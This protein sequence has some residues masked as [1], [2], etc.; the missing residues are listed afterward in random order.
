M[1]KIDAVQDLIKS[2]LSMLILS[3]LRDPRIGMVSVNDVRLSPDKRYAKVYISV[4][5]ND[6]EKKQSIEALQNAAGFLRTKV[7]HSVKL[8]HTPELTFVYDKTV[9]EAEKIEKAIDRIHG[10]DE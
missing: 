6:E 1:A 2:R 10:K 7:S 3:E 8:R 5:G 4:L 9:E